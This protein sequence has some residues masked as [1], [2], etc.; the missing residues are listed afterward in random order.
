MPKSPTWP[1]L[2]NDAGYRTA[3]VGKWHL[4]TEDK[5]HPTRFGYEYFMGIRTGGSPPK[6][7]TL[8]LPTDRNPYPI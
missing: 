1:K 5:Y 4:G 3:L 7:P 6:D 2:L 8:E